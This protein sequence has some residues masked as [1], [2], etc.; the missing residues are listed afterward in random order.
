MVRYLAMMSP[1][2]VR[3]GLADKPELELWMSAER[4]AE[5]WDFDQSVKEI[6]SHADLYQGLLGGATDELLRAEM[7]DFDGKPTSRGAFIVNMAIAGSA[8]YRTQLF[9]YLKSSGQAHLNSANLWS[10]V[11]VTLPA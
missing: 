6:G 9:L 1:T 10:G 8:A 5:A 2:V 7:I 4:A 11:D 3:Y